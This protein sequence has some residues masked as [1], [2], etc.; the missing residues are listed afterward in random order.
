MN[1]NPGL[2][3]YPKSYGDSCRYKCYQSIILYLPI[4]NML[5]LK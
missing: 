5:I 3:I 4:F 1:L 2:D